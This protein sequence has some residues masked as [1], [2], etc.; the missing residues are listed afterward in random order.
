MSNDIEREAFQKALS[1]NRFFR[2]KPGSYAPEEVEH[3]AWMVWQA[4][5]AQPADDHP[6]K[7]AYEKIER[8]FTSGNSV[9][10]REAV[11]QK[12]D[13]SMACAYLRNQMVFSDSS[14]DIE[15]RLQ[16]DLE[17][18]CPACGGSGHKD[19]CA[20]PE[21]GTP[22]AR[23][24][25]NG[26]PDPHGDR[27]NGER[28]SLCR[29]DVTDDELANEVYLHPNI[30]NLTAAKE[31]IRWL[32]RKLSEAAAQP[33]PSSGVPKG[34]LIRRVDDRITVQHPDIGG[35][36]ASKE[37]D[38]RSAIA[39]VIL[40]HLADAL[41]TAAPTPEAGQSGGVPSEFKAEIRTV[42]EIDDEYYS[43]LVFVSG[44]KSHPY[45][46]IP[47]NLDGAVLEEALRRLNHTNQP[48]SEQGGEW[49]PNMFWNA[50]C[51]EDGGVLTEH[52]L[53]EQCGQDLR[54]GESL[55][56]DVM[57]AKEL[58]A[59]QMLITVDENDELQW[60]WRVQPPKSKE[61]D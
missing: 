36:C 2:H 19:D 32:S 55:V 43:F 57:C 15:A 51:P 31:R 61:G 26:E 4:A 41:L 17:N 60:G 39:P 42:R 27:Y 12:Y 9:K 38:D 25:E 59:R 52:E 53:A 33:E 29:G 24:R 47:E 56:I 48:G 6:G 22:A 18:S 1:E 49:V 35:Y 10:V 40:Y 46:H 5:R 45:I 16:Y 21:P 58:P 34:W 20:Q 44:G 54:T 8:Q 28:S 30:G 11:I 37:S 13:W 50:D 23:W 7:A 3:I 14:E